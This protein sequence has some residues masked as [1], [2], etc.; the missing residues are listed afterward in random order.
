M[1]RMPREHKLPRARKTKEVRVAIIYDTKETGAA[2]VIAIVT[3]IADQAGEA[4]EGA[5]SVERLHHREHLLRAL[6]GR[7]MPT[8]SRPPSP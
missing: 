7:V 6:R 3:G 1:G 8:P 5:P 4:K 2:T